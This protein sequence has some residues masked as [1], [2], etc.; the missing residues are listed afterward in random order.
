[1]A[2]KDYT[3]SKSGLPWDGRADTRHFYL[4]QRLDFKTTTLL[5]ADSARVVPI[6]KGWEVRN[7]WTKVVTPEDGAA[8]FTIGKTAGGTEFE[9]NG[10]SDA[11]AGT[12]T[13]GIGGTDAGVTAAGQLYTADGYLF[14]DAAADLDTLVLDVVVEVVRIFDF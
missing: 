13:R 11:V 8:A 7:V 6:K 1:M 10:A 5:N 2:E 4:T 12:M 14:F 3:Q 9:G